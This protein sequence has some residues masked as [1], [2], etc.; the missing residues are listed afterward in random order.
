MKMA[1]LA[2]GAAVTFMTKTTSAK[3]DV[4]LVKSLP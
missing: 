2:L 3:R 1:S 4:D